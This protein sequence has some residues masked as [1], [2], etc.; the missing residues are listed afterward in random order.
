MRTAG[1]VYYDLAESQYLRRARSLL[2][3]TNFLFSGIM[4]VVRSSWRRRLNIRVDVRG[5]LRTHLNSKEYVMDWDV[6]PETRVGDVVARL[7]IPIESGWNAS[8][9]SRLVYDKDVLHDG[10]HLMIFEVIGGG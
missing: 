4:P 10:D 6:P 1:R 9:R 8:V 7:G 3:L 5:T 2:N